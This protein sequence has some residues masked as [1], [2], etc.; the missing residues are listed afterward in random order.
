MSKPRRHLHRDY[1]TA[2]CGRDI[3]HI[4]ATFEPKKT[5]C[6]GC[7]MQYIK[8][9]EQLLAGQQREVDKA[10]AELE[11]RKVVFSGQ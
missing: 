6:T 10:K 3:A 2:Y 11:Q 9:G 7:Q 8:E 4:L 1:N 5:T